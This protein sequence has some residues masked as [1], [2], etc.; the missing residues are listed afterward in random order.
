M[1]QTT[2]FLMVGCLWAGFAAGCVGGD[3]GRDGS[4]AR[5]VV[6]QVEQGLIGDR[7]DLCSR[8]SSCYLA[9]AEMSCDDEAS[10][11]EQGAAYENCDLSNAPAAEVC[12]YPL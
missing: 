7:G 3:G 11:A 4:A 8:W 10:C 6:G 12:P 5:S 2:W 1:R 9:C